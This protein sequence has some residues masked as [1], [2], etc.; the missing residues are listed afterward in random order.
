[1]S[2]MI[3]EYGEVTEYCSPNGL[4]RAERVAIAA[5]Q[6]NL[7]GDT[8]EL[9]R[10]VL[11]EFNVAKQCVASLKEDWIKGILGEYRMCQRLV[12]TH[13]RILCNRVGVLK[14]FKDSPESEG[15]HKS[16]IL[17]CGDCMAKETTKKH[18]G[19]SGQIHFQQTEPGERTKA[20]DEVPFQWTIYASRHEIQKIRVNRRRS[21]IRRISGS[22]GKRRR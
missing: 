5:V 21:K 18:T 17:G 14:G 16:G 1:M 19:C 15:R 10:Q 2:L 13:S 8:T 20:Q 3:R 22:D 9:M 7:E 4:M 12:Q 6:M 11:E